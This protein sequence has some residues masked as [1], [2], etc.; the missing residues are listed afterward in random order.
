MICSVRAICGRRAA[1][2][3]GIRY[4]ESMRVCL[5]V[6]ALGTVGCGSSSNP[7]S[8]SPTPV[9]LAGEWRGQ[10]N[11]PTPTGQRGSVAVT[12]TLTQSALA[13]AGEFTATQNISG[14]I[15]GTLSGPD[16]GATF[17]GRL[18]LRTPSDE[19]AVVC[20][21][22]GDISGSAAPPLR[23]T[24]PRVDFENCTGSL[25]DLSFTLGATN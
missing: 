2:A 10:L 19:P 20:L 4:T 1:M 7:V 12:L 18:T 22:T 25:T 17:R 13:V 9:N 6:V 5:L 15:D 11:L 24:A 21:A 16:S 3:L 14:R 23:W 8:P